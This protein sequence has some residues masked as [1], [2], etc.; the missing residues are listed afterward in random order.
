MY[1]FLNYVISGGVNE[2][3]TSVFCHGGFYFTFHFAV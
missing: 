3:V 2:Q 1:F